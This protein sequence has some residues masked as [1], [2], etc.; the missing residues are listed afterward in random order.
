MFNRLL[1][2]IIYL[3][4]FYIIFFLFKKNKFFIKIFY[5]LIINKI[6]NLFECKLIS[7]F[8]LKKKKKIILLINKNFV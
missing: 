4:F 2:Y 5:Y 7:Y 8:N 3:S 1:C 6:N